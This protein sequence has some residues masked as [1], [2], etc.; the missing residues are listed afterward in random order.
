ME[1]VFDQFNYGNVFITGGVNKGK[2]SILATLI[3]NCID[4]G[5][6]IYFIDAECELSKVFD[7]YDNVR[8]LFVS[9]NV[10]KVKH[11]VSDMNNGDTLI[12]DA[13]GMLSSSVKSYIKKFLATNKYRAII[14]SKNAND[15][16]VTQFTNVIALGTTRS[17]SKHIG[18]DTSTLESDEALINGDKIIKFNYSEF[19][20]Y[21][22]GLVISRLK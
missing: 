2:T 6:N 13:Y 12:I 21:K 8:S 1:R 7:K 19:I 3:E 20:G 11:F 9:S 18:I 5:E 15:I 17:F 14:A 4:K 10:V 16:N 22:A